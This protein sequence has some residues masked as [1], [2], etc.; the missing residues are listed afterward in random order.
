MLIHLLAVAD[1]PDRG[2]LVRYLSL[3]VSDRRPEDAARIFDLM[4]AYGSVAFSSEFATGVARSASAAMEGAFAG[5]HDSPA[6]RFV[7]KLVPF[8]IE[9]SS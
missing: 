7:S 3:D 6:R 1:P 5:L 4:T 2:W 8:M 9:R